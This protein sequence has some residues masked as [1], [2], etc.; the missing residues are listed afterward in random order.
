MRI[1]DR[2]SLKLEINFS[3]SFREIGIGSHCNIYE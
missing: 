3:M 1:E 2:L